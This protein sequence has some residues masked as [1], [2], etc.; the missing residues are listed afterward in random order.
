MQS[1]CTDLMIGFNCRSYDS[2]LEFAAGHCM[3]LYDTRPGAVL[4]CPHA[5]SEHSKRYRSPVG[6]T[7]ACHVLVTIDTQCRRMPL[8]ANA[9]TGGSCQAAAASCWPG[10]QKLHGADGSPH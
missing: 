7:S 4:G 1:L 8:S 10:P 5:H 6:P 3:T 2:F 9:A